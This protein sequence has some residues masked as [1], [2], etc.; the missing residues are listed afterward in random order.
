[1]RD[2]SDEELDSAPSPKRQRPEDVQTTAV[3]AFPVKEF[4][5]EATADDKSSDGAYVDEEAP[6]PQT[7]SLFFS[8]L[9]TDIRNLIYE[10]M[11]FDR[12]YI[13]PTFS[14]FV[15]SSKLASAEIDKACNHQFRVFMNNWKAN[16]ERKYRSLERMQYE[17]SYGADSQNDTREL[18]LWLQYPVPDPNGSWKDLYRHLNFVD[19]IMWPFTEMPFQKIWLYFV[20]RLADENQDESSWW[21]VKHAWWKT[22]DWE[23]EGLDRKSAHWLMIAMRPR[24]AIPFCYLLNDRTEKTWEVER[25]EEID[26]FFV[27]EDQGIVTCERVTSRGWKRERRRVAL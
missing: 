5:D 6:Y 22:F 4:S 10:H 2:G 14:G 25:L 20:P 15:L 27:S 8:R 18:S 7:Q 9:N 12:F 17:V 24:V 26:F 13:S 1:M 16:M 21:R 11:N 19:H 3:E 23:G